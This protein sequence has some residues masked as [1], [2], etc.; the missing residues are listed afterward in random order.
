[1]T[2]NR[3]NDQQRFLCKTMYFTSILR[4][5]FTTYAMPIS[6]GL[7]PGNLTLYSIDTHFN[8]S[9]TDSSKTL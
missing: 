3:S 5:F 9:T 4:R 6:L 1:M 2:V 7:L 8:A